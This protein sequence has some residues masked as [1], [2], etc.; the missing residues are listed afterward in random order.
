MSEVSPDAWPASC[1]ALGC[2]LKFEHRNS[3]IFVS[4][5]PTLR[6]ECTTELVIEG[7]GKAPLGWVL[8]SLNKWSDQIHGDPADPDAPH[9]HAMKPWRSLEHMHPGFQS[10]TGCAGCGQL[11]CRA[12]TWTSRV[13]R[14]HL[15]NTP[16]RH[17]P[18]VGRSQGQ[19]RP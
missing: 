17:H 13:P 14:E 18:P 5:Q 8:D 12:C 11:A 10:V 7:E 1:I 3:A 4:H 6:P 9:D 15:L 19:M 16:R 2:V